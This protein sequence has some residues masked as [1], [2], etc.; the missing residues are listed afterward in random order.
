MSKTTIAG[1][2]LRSL[3]R[4]K[5]IV[6]ALL[7]QLVIAGFSSFLVVGLTSLYE[8]GAAADDV[9]VGATGEETDALVEAAGEVDG[10]VVRPYDD[11]SEA[12]AAF[13]DNR[14]QATAHVERAE[15]RIAVRI[16]APQASVQKTFIVVQLRAALE[17]LERNERADRSEYLS[18]LPLSVPPSVDA[19]PYFGF[20]YT[21]LVPLLVFLPVFISGAVVVDSLT[22]EI[23]RGTLELLRVTPASLLDI[24][25]GKAGVMAVLTPLQVV[26]WLALLAIN[27]IAIAN[28]APILAIA[29]SFA[30]LAVV[31]AAALAVAIPV[32]QRAQLTY[33]FGMLAAFAAVALLPEHPATSIALFAINS[34]TTTTYAHLAGYCLVAV[35]AVVAF[36]WWIG[37][38][39]AESLG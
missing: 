33:S 22:E 29:T 34:P 13:E 25:D 1:R 24:V 17:T 4:E 30:A 37:T 18:V 9:I 16:E 31:F 10:L 21:V 23:E 14:V 28:V 8:P 36:R 3:S 2:E 15:G 38:L 26:L 12:R 5:T 39:D 7:I 32:R 20:S 27:D 35:A 11:R 6:L 19:S